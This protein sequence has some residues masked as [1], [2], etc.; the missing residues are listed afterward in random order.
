MKRKDFLKRGAMGLG[1]VLAVPVIASSCGSDDGPA[2]N[3]SCPSTPS[4]IKGPFPN[5]T[6]A[7]VVRANIIGNRMGIP[8]QVN[9]TIQ[10]ASNECQPMAAA[11]VDLWHCDA[12]GNYSEYNDQIDGDFTSENF[13]RGRQT[14]DASGQVSFISIYP[15][16]Y[17][18]RAPHLHLEVFNAAGTSL[19][20]TQVAF[21]EAVSNTVYANNGYNGTFDTSNASDDSFGDSLQA[22]LP[23][24]LTGNPTDG[25]V[26]SKTITVFG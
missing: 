3:P 25:Y 7:D 20:V 8:L 14:A 6:P 17:P 26:Y 1:T 4:E 12:Q 13:L 19:L 23:D 24:S 21:E 16:W 15:G 2:Q 22:N 10:D 11:I 9:L 5:R 18:G